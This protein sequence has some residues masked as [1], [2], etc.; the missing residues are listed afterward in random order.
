MRTTLEQRALE[1]IRRSGMM[2][3]GD[4]VAVAVSGGADSVALLRVLQK[5]RGELGITLLVAHLDHMLRGAESD[6][7]ADFVEA[8]SLSSGLEFIVA[9]EDVRAAAAR[10]GWNLEDAA[11]R[12][13]YSFFQRILSEKRANCIAVAHTADDQAETV[14]G[15]VMRGTGLTGLAGIHPIVASS[16]G[17]SIVRP[18]LTTRR[19]DLREYLK[20]HGQ[21]WREDATNLDQSRLRARIRAQLLPVLERDFSPA[22]VQ[23]LGDLARF[24]REEESMWTALVEDRL[25]GCTNASNPA[26]SLPSATILVRDLLSPLPL[27]A[28][29]GQRDSEATRA[30]TERLIRRLYEKVRGDRCDL[31][32]R[33]VEHVIRLASESTSGKRVTLP[34]KIEVE[35]VFDELVFSRAGRAGGSGPVRETKLQASTYQYLVSLPQ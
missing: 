24:A 3:A 1:F 7:D 23:H 16:A 18:F 12:L 9:R 21:G 26:D 27:L 2:S 33:H 14:L 29:A 22:I 28:A 31:S 20:A 6:G 4:R 17:G 34:G 30:L 10:R 8:L 35:R 25:R 19:E 32:S 11:R 15:H 13:R 5:L